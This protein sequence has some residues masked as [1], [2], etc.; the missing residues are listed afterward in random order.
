MHAGVQGLEMVHSFKGIEED[1][2]RWLFIS[3][4]TQGPSFCPLPLFKFKA[5]R[6]NF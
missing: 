4:D 2:M 5:L 1:R 3:Q 6:L